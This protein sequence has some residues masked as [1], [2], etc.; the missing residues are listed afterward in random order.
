MMHSQ[1]APLFCIFTVW[2]GEVLTSLHCRATKVT[3]A[4]NLRTNVQGST[5]FETP[6]RE[7]TPEIFSI[8][9]SGSAIIS[10]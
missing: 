9:L 10:M 3:P 5:V 7:N 4:H 2:G 6:E 8:K 1:E